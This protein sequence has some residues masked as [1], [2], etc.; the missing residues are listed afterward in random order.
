MGSPLRGREFFGFGGMGAL[1]LGGWEL[2][3][4]GGVEFGGGEVV[5]DGGVLAKGMGVMGFGGG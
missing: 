4:M 5:D 3:M 1:N 2:V